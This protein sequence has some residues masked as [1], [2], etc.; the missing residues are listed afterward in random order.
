LWAISGAVIMKM[1]SSTSITSTSG[2]MLISAIGAEW[3]APPPPPSPLNAL[4]V[5]LDGQA[6]CWMR[7]A[8]W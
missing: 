1:I 6:A 2:I 4:A 5:S 3:G 8:R 7:W